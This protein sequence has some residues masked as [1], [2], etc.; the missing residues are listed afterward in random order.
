ML[1]F[2]IMTGSF[3]DADEVPAGLVHLQGRIE[4]IDGG[5]P[6]LVD[7]LHSCGGSHLRRGVSLTQMRDSHFSETVIIGVGLLPKCRLLDEGK[8]LLV[9]GG[10]IVANVFHVLQEGLG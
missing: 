2:E 10:L 7:V 4:V 3:V 1:R 9:G 6:Q 5:L 8:A